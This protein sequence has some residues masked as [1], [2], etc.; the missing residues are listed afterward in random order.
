MGYI[1]NAIVQFFGGCDILT[2]SQ[3][4][5]GFELV[6]VKMYGPSSTVH[7]HVL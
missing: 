5:G 7:T 3:C 6:S 4:V 2:T 1:S